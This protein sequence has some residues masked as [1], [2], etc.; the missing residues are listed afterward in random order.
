MERSSSH[1]RVL[2]SQKKPV[3][4]LCQRA[5]ISDGSVGQ[6]S[7]YLRRELTQEELDEEEIRP[8]LSKQIQHPVHKFRR[9]A[10]AQALQRK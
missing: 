5:A 8:V 9:F 3:S 4:L 1:A 7:P 2:N 10:V 6:S